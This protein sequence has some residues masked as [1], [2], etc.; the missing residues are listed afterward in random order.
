MFLLNPDRQL[1][2]REDEIILRK[3]TIYYFNFIVVVF[4]NQFEEREVWCVV[5]N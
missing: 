1:M 3:N 5:A 4:S 2:S